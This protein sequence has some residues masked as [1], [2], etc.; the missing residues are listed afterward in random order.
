MAD[1]PRETPLQKAYP[2]TITP[3]RV[4]GEYL[5]RV[6]E[7]GRQ[8]IE[9]AFSAFGVEIVRRITADTYLVRL[10]RDP[11]PEAVTAAAATV[12]AIHAVQPNYRYRTF[13]GR[14]T[15]GR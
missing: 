7:N 9:Q 13:P 4:P 12:P 6:G 2:R 1:P 11:G 10:E 8:G 15:P 5:V 14:S 3:D